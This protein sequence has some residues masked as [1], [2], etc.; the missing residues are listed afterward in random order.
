M[1][2]PIRST[3]LVE[4]DAALHSLLDSLLAEV[5]AADAAAVPIEAP[6]SPRAPALNA[7]AARP[8][9]TTGEPGP[10]S[11]DL[12]PD[13][14]RPDFRALFFRVGEFRFA[15]PLVQMCSVS[16]LPAQLARVPAQPAW[17][18][19]VARHRGR[20]VVVADIGLLLG[21]QTRCEAPRYLLVIGDGHAALACDR[22]EDAAAIGADAVRWRDPAAGRAWLAGLLVREMCALLNPAAVDEEMRHGK[23]N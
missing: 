23:C 4:H 15:M 8:L 9:P 20:P 11:R 10:A 12:T 14:A 13:W 7:D 17:H 2:R 5:P 16:A 6:T 21:L 18:L 19:G 22:V 3:R 1:P